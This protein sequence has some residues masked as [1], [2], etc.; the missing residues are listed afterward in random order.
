MNVASELNMGLR[1][2]FIQRARLLRHTPGSTNL[3]G[4]TTL[5]QPVTRS[6]CVQNATD[7]ISAAYSQP[8]APSSG[9][10]QPQQDSYGTPQAAPVSAAYT[11]PAPAVVYGEPA[12]IEEPLF[13]YK[14]AP[15]S[16]LTSLAAAEADIPPS[17]GYSSQ[18][19][20][21]AVPGLYQATGQAASLAEEVSTGSVY[22]QPQYG[23]STTQQDDLFTIYYSKDSPVRYGS[24]RSPAGL[25]HSLPVAASH[26]L[27]P[28]YQL[29]NHLVGGVGA[30]GAASSADCFI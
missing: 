22:V 21:A 27:P 1:P 12:P 7:P 6:R 4:A 23:Q 8:A 25:T 13:E 11:Q 9:Y 18:P 2:S 24:K 10:A 5:I 14:G 26:E 19:S 17:E 28:L 20:Y 29:H 3:R 16:D 30:S 15:V